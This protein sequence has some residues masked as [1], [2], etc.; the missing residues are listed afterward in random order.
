VLLNYVS[1][2]KKCK[3]L[4]VKKKRARGELSVQFVC[5][6]PD[7]IHVALGFPEDHFHHTKCLFIA[8]QAVLE[9]SAEDLVVKKNATITNLKF[10]LHCLRY[11]YPN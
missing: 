4:V 10:L 2:V 3:N 1:P 11:S 5:H 6:H 9:N 7:N 8:S